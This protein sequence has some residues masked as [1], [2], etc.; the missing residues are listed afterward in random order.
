MPSNE[1][2]FARLSGRINGEKEAARFHRVMEILKADAKE[3]GISIKMALFLWEKNR[4][5]DCTIENGRIF[6][7]KKFKEFLTTEGKYI[8]VEK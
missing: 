8:D 3:N 6:L 1:R 7:E 4:C 5:I 2:D